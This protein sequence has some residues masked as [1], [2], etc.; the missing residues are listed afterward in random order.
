MTEADW[1][2]SASPSSL[3]KFL[4]LRATD[5]KLR[6]FGCACCRLFWDNLPGEWAWQ[7]IEAAEQYADDQ[8]TEIAM[9]RIRQAS[10]KAQAKLRGAEARLGWAVIQL[11]RRRLFLRYGRGSRSPGVDRG[12][13]GIFFRSGSAS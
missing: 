13:W 3:L 10:R 7:A 5:R 11:L 2:T 6:L 12:E 1:L 4:R 9:E 8:V